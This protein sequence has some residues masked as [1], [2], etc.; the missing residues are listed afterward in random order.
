LS[1]SF[2]SVIRLDLQKAKEWNP[3]GPRL[4]AF[5]A[6]QFLMRLLFTALLAGFRRAENKL[7][8]ADVALS[9]SLFL[10]CFFPLLKLIFTS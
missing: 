6:L 7:I 2:S 5:F 10:Y 9:L 8:I 3:Y 4:F 1:R